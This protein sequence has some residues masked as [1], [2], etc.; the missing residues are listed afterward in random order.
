VSGPMISCTSPPE[1]K[2]SPAP[3]KTMARISLAATS[4]RKRSRSSVGF[5]CER[6]LALRAIQSHHGD[7]SVL[8]PLKMSRIELLGL[9]RRQL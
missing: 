2:F 1:Q 3:V 5:E 9:E 7:S 8:A 6:V 4:A